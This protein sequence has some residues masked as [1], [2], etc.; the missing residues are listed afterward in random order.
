MIM[1]EFIAIIGGSLIIEQFFRNSLRVGELYLQSIYQV[2]SNFFM[3]LSMFLRSL[4]G[5]MPA[6]GLIGSQLMASWIRGIRM[7]A[8]NL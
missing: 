6:L 4:S 8:N 5:L 7:G 3:F 2:D 1:G